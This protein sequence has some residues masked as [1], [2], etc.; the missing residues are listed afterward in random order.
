[1]AFSKSFP[2][3]SDKSVYPKWEDVFLSEDEERGVESEARHENIRLMR[4][5]LSD[6]KKILA[7]ENL[8]GY[9][10]SLIDLAVALFDKRASHA[11]FWKENRAKEKFDEQEGNPQE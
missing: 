3:R 8:K 5:C 4:E 2:K 9:E 1:M 10:T 6:A 11:V 7:D